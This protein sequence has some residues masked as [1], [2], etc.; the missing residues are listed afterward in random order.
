MSGVQAASG[1]LLGFL[2]GADLNSTSDQGIAIN[3]S[4][5]VLRKI[6]V[7]NCSGSATTAVGGFYAATS[8][9]TALV[10]NTQV[11]SAMTGPTL[12]TSATLNSTATSTRRTETTLYFSLTTPQGSAMTADIYIYGDRIS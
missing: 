6:V 1:N 10:A 11:Y 8:K 12:I 4:N 3:S 5:Y 9:A 7:T 2:S